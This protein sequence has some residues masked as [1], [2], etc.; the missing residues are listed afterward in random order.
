MLWQNTT[1]EYTCRNEEQ[2]RV[3]VQRQVTVTAVLTVQT[4]DV[5]SCQIISPHS[6]YLCPKSIPSYDI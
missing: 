6:S 5:S 3:T 4:L 1:C 2:R